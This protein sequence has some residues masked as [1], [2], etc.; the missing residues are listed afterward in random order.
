MPE[1]R[2]LIELLLT[3]LQPKIDH[4]GYQRHI[5]ARNPPLI[6]EDGDEIEDIDD[7]ESIDGSL[8]E[9]NPYG[10]IRL[11]ELLAPLTSA[12]DLATHPSMS[13]P[14]YSNHITELA[15]NSRE[16]LQREEKSLWRAKAIMQKLLGDD[17]WLPVGLMETDYD[18]DLLNEHVPAAAA[19]SAFVGSMDADNAERQG[20]SWEDPAKGSED[21][22]MQ[23]TPQPAGAQQTGPQAPSGDN[24]VPMENGIE[25]QDTGPARGESSQ[26]T[27]AQ[28]NARSNGTNADQSTEVLHQNGTRQN[29]ADGDRQMANADALKQEDQGASAENAGDRMQVDITNGTAEDGSDD[30]EDSNSQQTSHR[31]TTRAQRRA[32]SQQSSAPGSPHTLSPHS[33]AEPPIHPLFQFPVEN[34]LDRDM[35]LPPNEAEDTRTWLLMYIQK[36]EE[37]VRQTRALYMGLMEADRK[38]KMVLKWTK[39]EGHVGEMSDGE[40]WVDK[41]EWGLT[42]DLVKGKEEEEE[43]GVVQ[44]KKTRARRREEK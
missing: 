33:P 15:N 34:L 41:E 6:D 19:T 32:N 22:N 38:R 3:S 12:A 39:A 35:G 25:R 9:D 16:V 4:A 21:T 40:D 23:A 42:E 24:D 2:R 11:E 14:Y 28:Q 13:I 17:T 8:A 43:E 29:G 18:R 5:I 36:Q 44:G 20:A 31:M 30:G 1:L 37:V 10:D 26:Q 27:E 7:D